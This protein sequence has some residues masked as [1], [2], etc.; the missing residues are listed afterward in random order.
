MMENEKRNSRKGLYVAL[1]VLVAL[2]MWLFV[3]ITGNGTGSP[4]T[5]TQWYT[6]IPIEYV[7]ETTLADKG[8][9]LLEENTDTTVDLK[10]EGTYWALANLQAEDIRVTADLG[11]V[12]IAGKQAVTYT[13]TLPGASYDNTL[14]VKERAPSNIYVN[15][16]ELHSKEIPVYCE[17]VGNVA[18][19]C[20]AGQLQMSH[21]ELSIRGQQQDV[22]PVAYAKVILDI[23]TDAGS[24]VSQAV[25][26]QFY[27][28]NDKV[29]TNEA[30][31][32]SVNEIQVVL[33]ISINKE[34]KLAMNFIEAP[35]I[36]TSS[37]DYSIQPET[38]TV[39][40]DAVLLKDIDKIVLNDFDLM[41]LTN[42]A[43]THSYPIVI[44]D[45]CKNLSGITQAILQ[46][47]RRDYTEYQL[48]VG[49]FE[50]MNLPEGKNVEIMTLDLPVRVFGT[51]NDVAGLMSEHLTAVVDLNE[52]TDAVG[53]YTVPVVL[54]SS[55]G[56]IGF[57]GDYEVQVRI[58]T[59]DE[60]PDEPSE[61][62]NEEP[63]EESQ[64]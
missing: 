38:I 32:A 50:Y 44:P 35:G 24:S 33:P 18:E 2:V 15:I 13:Y 43:T 39:S 12:A 54:E 52:F 34:L 11:F 1:S 57:I 47:S 60:L 40:G 5:T 21:V 55:H 59:E 37:C 31:H 64:E 9:M 36:R 28:K 49:N 16:A 26:Y 58:Y 29:I 30:I 19:G 6:D 23:G 20:F 7:R 51:V 53:V 10:V 56:D 62:E 25:S 8:L 46:I 42:E 3:N 14:K 63:P 4:R 17:V 61:E 48:S 41:T 22:E 27:D 45:G